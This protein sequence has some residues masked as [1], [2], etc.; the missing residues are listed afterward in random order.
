[1]LSSQVSN[2]S[3]S[4]L[5][6]MT[7]GTWICQNLEVS[8]MSQFSLDRRNQWCDVELFGKVCGSNWVTF[9][10]NQK[11]KIINV[12]G[13]SDWQ[14]HSVLL[15]LH[16]AACNLA[17]T[18]CQGCLKRTCFQS[19]DQRHNWQCRSQSLLML[20]FLWRVVFFQWKADYYRLFN[21]ASFL[22]SCGLG[23]ARSV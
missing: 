3:S 4:K 19:L 14:P 5:K 11:F 21:Q 9:Y 13:I 22:R 16:R 1:M 12:S 10:C 15:W 23:G 17:S 2:S 6:H 7:L 18:M 20:L 8:K